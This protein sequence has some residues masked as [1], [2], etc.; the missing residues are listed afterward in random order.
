[1]CNR[2]FAIIA[3]CL[4][5]LVGAQSPTFAQAKSYGKLNPQQLATCR[6]AM[7]E[8]GKLQATGLRSKLKQDAK[9]AATSLDSSELEK[10]KR[11]I[12]LDEIVMFKCRIV[13]HPALGTKRRAKNTL[14]LASGQAAN[15][16]AIPALPSKKPKTPRSA[17]RSAGQSLAVP[18]PDRRPRP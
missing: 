5:S 6:A 2:V 7:A 10:L 11:L 13:A 16:V 9:L 4:A 3:F 18:L 17:Q 14:A 1:M 15:P 8:R 12:Q